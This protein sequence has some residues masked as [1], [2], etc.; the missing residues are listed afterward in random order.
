MEEGFWSQ[1][2]IFWGEE[3]SHGFQENER[4][5]QSLLTGYKRRTIEN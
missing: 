5:N 4:G 2:N 1:S 3:G